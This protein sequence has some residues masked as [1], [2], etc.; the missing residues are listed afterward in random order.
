MDNRIP[1]QPLISQAPLNPLSKLPQSRA[2]LTGAIL[3]MTPFGHDRLSDKW[4]RSGLT[5]GLSGEIWQIAI[6]LRAVK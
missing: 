4:R 6:F 5:R 2:P 1:R 3:L